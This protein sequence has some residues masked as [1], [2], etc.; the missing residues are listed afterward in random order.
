[1][2]K[3]IH[4]YPLKITDE[5]SVNLP[6]GYEILTI[7]LQ[8]VVMGPNRLYLWA[9]VDLDELVIEMIN[10]SIIGTGNHITPTEQGTFRK[11]I[12]TV[13]DGSHVW[14]VFQ[15]MNI[16]VD[17]LKMLSTVEKFPPTMFPEDL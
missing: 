1:M 16:H 12:N 3:V 15:V 2:N 10:I 14:H 8:E 17:K 11:Y 6:K 7:Q 9:I 13:Q 5:Q 4:K